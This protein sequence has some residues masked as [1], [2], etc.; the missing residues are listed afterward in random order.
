MEGETGT[1]GTGPGAPGGRTHAL[2]TAF[3]AE[4]GWA[5]HGADLCPAGTQVNLWLF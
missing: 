2:P 4:A 5:E 3:L 1:E